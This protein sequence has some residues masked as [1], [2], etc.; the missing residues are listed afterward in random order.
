[1]GGGLSGRSPNHSRGGA[2]GRGKP[3][4]PDDQKRK[5]TAFT[6]APELLLKV[7]SES[8]RLGLSRSELLNRAVAAYFTETPADQVAE[9]LRLVSVA[10]GNYLEA[11]RDTPAPP[12]APEQYTASGITWAK[13]DGW[14]GQRQGSVWH[15]PGF[16][17]PGFALTIQNKSGV[18]SMQLRQNRPK[19]KVLT[20]W[21]DNTK[22]FE[23]FESLALDKASKWVAEHKPV[24]SLA[25][26]FERDPE[27][28]LDAAALADLAT[29]NKKIK[30]KEQTP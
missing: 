26:L 16:A 27:G 15:S 29:K 7:E 5:V 22:S 8:D 14:K 1:M 21:S 9:A 6:L 2:R 12:A 17:P 28:M 10:V 11:R 25:E 13:V 18:V 30:S 24:N 23:A 3:T 19:A 4:M 20:D